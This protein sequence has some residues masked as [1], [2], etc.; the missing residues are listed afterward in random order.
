L[1]RAGLGESLACPG[2]QGETGQNQPQ[3]ER[4]DGFDDQ[5][6]LNLRFHNVANDPF[7]TGLGGKVTGKV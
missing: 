5:N 6:L 2:K 1:R 7:L 4:F 3:R